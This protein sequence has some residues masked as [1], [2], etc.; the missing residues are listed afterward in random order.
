[1]VVV[2]GMREGIIVEGILGIILI[3]AAAAA[4]AAATLVMEET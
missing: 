1:V 3:I 2:V 4:A